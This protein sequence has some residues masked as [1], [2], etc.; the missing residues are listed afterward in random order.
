MTRRRLVTACVLT[1][2]AGCKKEEEA[3]AAPKPPEA[4]TWTDV[5]AVNA[6]IPMPLRER[7]GF[8]LTRIRQDAFKTQLI[9]TVAA[10]STWRQDRKD[11]AWLTPDAEDGFGSMTFFSVGVGCDGL[12]EPKDWGPI[13]EKSHRAAVAEELV[14]V[15][16]DEKLP[17][18]QTL[19]AKL[20][21]GPLV[22]LQVA[23]WKD[24][25]PQYYTCRAG[26]E[27]ETAAALAAF[28]KACAR[29]EVQEIAKPRK[30]PIAEE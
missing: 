1:L 4:L 7:L 11:L 28:E 6:L 22:L 16:K 13:V 17:G 14:E 20:S 24:G 29:V 19:I 5:Y 25:D 18:R 15:I 30:E 27:R 10:P 2:A 9:Y 8:G 12:C 3:T 26:L 21:E 23:W